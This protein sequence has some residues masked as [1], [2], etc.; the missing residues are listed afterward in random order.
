MVLRVVIAPLVEEKWDKHLKK[1]LGWD[2]WFTIDMALL[3]VMTGIGGLQRVHKSVLELLPADGV[4]KN[5][6]TVLAEVKTLQNGELVKYSGAQAKGDVA[7]A[8]EV[9][10]QIS[11]KLMPSR[12]DAP[13]PFMLQLWQKLPLFATVEIP[14]LEATSSD[15]KKLLMG[16]AA[17]D[18]MWETLKS[19]P[20]AQLRQSDVDAL[21]IW[22][23]LLSSEAA[24]RHKHPFTP[25]Q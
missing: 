6:E 13:S 24:L 5:V 3:R 10:A 22:A 25:S 21:G 7:A 17:V 14:P 1:L 12:V 4:P 16:Q 9:L 11:C 20:E 2:A 23:Y 18:K 15:D 19:T 8:V